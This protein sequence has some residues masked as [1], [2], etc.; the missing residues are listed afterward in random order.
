MAW[1]GTARYCALQ[2]ILLVGLGFQL[3]YLY[4]FDLWAAFVPLAC[5]YIMLLSLASLKIYYQQRKPVSGDSNFTPLLGVGD[6]D[7][8]VTEGSG[9]EEAK[10]HG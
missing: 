3:I 7:H 1:H 8:V 10:V 5:E 6:E 9:L 2:I 4:H